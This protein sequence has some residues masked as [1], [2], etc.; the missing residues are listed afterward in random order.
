MSES[1]EKIHKAIDRSRNEKQK[2]V[3]LRELARSRCIQE[4]KTMDRSTSLMDR[5]TAIRNR[6]IALRTKK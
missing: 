6:S 2:S 1:S 5:S 3:L 4:S